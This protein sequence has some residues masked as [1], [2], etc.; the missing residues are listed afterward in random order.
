MKSKYHA[1]LK[2]GE[3]SPYNAVCGI[4][5]GLLSDFSLSQVQTVSNNL[6]LFYSIPS[7]FIR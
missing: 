3:N 1:N 6:T 7:S 5:G 4:P 2:E